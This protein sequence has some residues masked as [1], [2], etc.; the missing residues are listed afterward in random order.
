M[1]N[2]NFP[3]F[4]RPVIPALQ[5]RKLVRQFAALWF[6]RL[7]RAQSF[8]NTSFK[9]LRLRFASFGVGLERNSH[10]WMREQRTRSRIG[11]G[12]LHGCHAELKRTMEQAIAKL[13]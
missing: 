7:D 5:K 4:T 6:A 10:V 11:I 2:E 1:G 12:M 3:L 13:E 9:G 8:G